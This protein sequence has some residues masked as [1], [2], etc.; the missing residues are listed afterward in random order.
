MKTKTRP[1]TSAGSISDQLRTALTAPGRCPHAVAMSAG[2][3]PSVV[4]RF[5]S[6]AR[7]LNSETIDRL[8]AVLGLRMVDTGRG[9]ASAGR[10]KGVEGASD[11]AA[12][13][14]ARE[15]M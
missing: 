5:V 10:R 2:V 14:G 6:G 12:P 8:A 7:G 13:S 4:S 9:R 15:G 3:A 1:R 11:P